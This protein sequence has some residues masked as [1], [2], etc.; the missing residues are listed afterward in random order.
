MFEEVITNQRPV[1][2]ETR[3]ALFVPDNSLFQAVCVAHGHTTAKLLLIILILQ[4]YSDICIPVYTTQYSV[5]CSDTY[6]LILHLY[7]Q[8]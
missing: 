4:L 7:L 3:S 8:L 5:Q 2:Q 1:R 6:T